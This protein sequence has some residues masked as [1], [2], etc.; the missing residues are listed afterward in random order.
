MSRLHKSAGVF[1]FWMLM[2]MVCL[3]QSIKGKVTDSLGKPISYA[4]INLKNSAGL[5]IAY[6]TSD[7]GGLYSLGIPANADKN[8]LTLEASCIGFKKAGLPVNGF[9]TPYNFKLA[10]AVHQLQGVTIKNNRPRLRVS[11]DTTSYKVSDFSSPQDRVIGDVIKK[12]PGIDVAKD[13]KISYNGKAISNLYIGGDNLLDDKYNIAT[14]TIPH[15][16][17]DQVQVMENHQPVKMLRDKVVSEDVALNLTIKKDAKLQL[18][19]QETIGAGLPKKYDED[20]N[21]MMFKDKYKAINYLRGNNTGYDV[22][23]DLVSHNSA[24]HMQ[25]LDNDQPGTVLSLGTAGDPDLPRNRYLFNQS[26]IVNLNNLVN[27]KKDVQ[28]RANI[29]YLRDSQHQDYSRLSEVYLPGDTIRYT[30]KQNNKWR[31]DLIHTQ[32]TL[33]VNQNKYYLN[34]NLVTDYN[35]NTSYSNLVSNGVPVNQTFKD[36]LFNFSNELNWMKTFHNDKIMEVYSYINRTSEPES[37]I[38]EPNLNPDIFNNGVSY[39]LLTQTVNIPTWFSNNYLAYKIPGQHITQSYK[40]GFSSQSQTLNSGLL[41]TQQNNVVNPV[42]DSTRNSLNWSRNKAYAEAD[43]DIPGKILKIEASLP[44]SWQ[45][46]HYNDDYYQLSNSLNRLYF[47]PRLYVKY[48]SGIE[49]YFTLNYGLRN[50]IGS[51]QDVYRGYILTNY[52]T[53][54]ANSADLTERQSQNA[55]LGFNYRKAITL[56]FFS[57]NVNYSHIYANNIAASILTNNLQQ[58]VV[59]PYDNKTDAWAVSGYISKYNFDLQTTFSAGASWQTAR[60]NQLQNGLILPFNT[61]GETLNVG[62]ESK[63]S[64]KVNLSYKANYSQITSK[65]TAVAGSSKF[66]RLIQTAAIEYNPLNTLQFNIAA[67]HYYTHQQQAND[68]KYFFADATMRYKFSKPKIDV[69]LTAQNLFN[70]KNYTSLYLSANVF[71]SSTYNIPGRMLLAKVM[72]NL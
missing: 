13:G 55:G 72:F 68:L 14:G 27:L 47:N 60:L 11:G 56:F 18:I 1:I 33:N 45:Q 36:N 38:I 59:L 50:N 3:G 41:V 58:R 46:T 65:S 57:L 12:L 7:A 67:D 62:A 30:E 63:L 53:L 17:V 40:A 23:G 71:T 31:P 48:Q 21:A 49:N 4:G 5:I 43:F 24:E 51:I 61:V 26:G 16:V 29:S 37:R 32:F 34:D 6:T 19:G 15:G 70:V 54:Y 25:R 66:Q 64:S 20:L 9:T 2:G 10:G 8:G 35:H 69:Q 44:F 52:R 28:L 42:G 22:A 39:S